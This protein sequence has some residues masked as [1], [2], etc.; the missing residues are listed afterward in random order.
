MH[1]Q[2]WKCSGHYDLFHDM[3]QTCRQCKK[4]FRAD[5]V[6]DM[7]REKEWFTSV[8]A[9]LELLPQSGFSD[10]QCKEAITKWVN[11]KGKKLAPGLALVRKYAEKMR[12]L[13][14]G[15][16][17]DFFSLPPGERISYL[18]TESPTETGLQMPCPECGG[19]LTEPREF[20]LMFETY[21]GAVRDESSKTFLRPE[22]AQGIFVNF[23]NV[24]DST[25]VKVPF[26]IAQIG[27]SFRN[28]I[29]PRN[30]HVPLARV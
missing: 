13:E 18:A 5:Q 4:L 16:G 23:K 6:A 28:E 19:D 12:D 8:Q 15:P 14:A 26:G 22:T 21:T 7:L 27:K 9:V 3:M 11:K 20:N 29:T 2:I 17:D 10:P 24:C 1:P 25:R 30:Y